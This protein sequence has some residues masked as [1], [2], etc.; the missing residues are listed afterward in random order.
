[1][2]GSVKLPRG[3]AV[4]CIGFMGAGKTT[5][6][7]SVARALGKEA[8]DVDQ[9]IEARLQKPIERV[10]AEQGE[11]AFRATE[12]QVTLEL[13]NAPGAAVLALGGGAIG[14][15]SV[16]RSLAQHLT[17]WIDVDA[18]VA[19]SRSEGTGRPLARDHA[20]FER[21]YAEREPVYAS[22]A[23]V[24]VPAERANAML[25]VLS[26]LRG[27]PR[28]AKMLW[29]AA[30]SGDY[31]AYIGPGLVGEQRFWP[32]G[33]PGRRF[34]VT[35]GNAGRLYGDAL[36]R[37]SGRVA[38]MPGEQSKTIAHAEIVWNELVRAGM[39]REDVVVALGGG[40]VGDLAGFC[41][42][43]YQRGVRYVQ[44]PTT[45]VAQVDAAYGG[46]TGV[47]L[48]EAKNYV[49]AYQQPSAVIADTATLATLPATEVAAGY[50]EVVKTAL[51]AGGELWERVR[52]GADPTAPEVIVACARTKLRVVA[53][54][55]RDAGLRQ[56]LN[57]GHTVGHAIETA[58]G[59][60]RYRHGEAV[61]L[62]LLAALRLS[63]R[64]DLRDEVRALLQ[65]RGL[66]TAL[67][68]ADPDAIVM[69][70][71]RDKKRLGE[72][73]VPFVLLEA[74]GDVRP[75]CAVGSRELIAAVRE[76]AP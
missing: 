34:L 24:T 70:T 67:H 29:A 69:A 1:M 42:A 35:D 44:A 55:E 43:T 62:G 19:W 33:V 46:K 28:G 66:P 26:A 51:I 56:V 39:T 6:A 3:R 75:G 41:A 12:E 64:E 59:Y 8:I 21:L 9:V 49:G 20:R 38:I 72:G 47:D 60:A 30:A 40:V 74:P 18:S 31:P 54:D 37:L 76:L 25:G 10:F 17:I 57:L 63:G 53:R 16:R 32:D 58:T 36:Q 11:S 23:D 71:A 50:A 68:G 2:A 27:L 13:L 5:A 14:A 48:P 45:L 65:A 15:E 7:A 73:G 4:V 61:G 52:S 22:L